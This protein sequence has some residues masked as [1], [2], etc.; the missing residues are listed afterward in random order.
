MNTERKRVAIA[1][2]S[3]W[4][5]QIDTGFSVPIWNKEELE[6]F[7][8][9]ELPP[10]TTCLNAMHEAEGHLTESQRIEYLN[11]LADMFPFNGLHYDHGFIAAIQATAS[12]RAD[13]FVKTI[14]STTP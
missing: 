7:G 14:K 2:T 13:A 1:E 12:Q 5:R 10:Y 8:E 3:G 6:A 4:V 9:D 11:T